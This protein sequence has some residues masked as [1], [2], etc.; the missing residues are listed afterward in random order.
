MERLTKR[1]ENGAVEFFNMYRLVKNTSPFGANEEW[2]KVINRL[3]EYEDTGLT[4]DSII[5]LAN[6]GSEVKGV[7]REQYA[8]GHVRVVSYDE[9]T[10]WGTF[11]LEEKNTLDS[12]VMSANICPHC[13]ERI[14]MNKKD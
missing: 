1:H 9:T 7:M 5:T 6:L 4:P 13:S 8:K 12:E 2:L 3:A 11:F 14:K 10:K